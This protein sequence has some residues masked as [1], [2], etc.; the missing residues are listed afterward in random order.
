MRSAR[1]LASFFGMAAT[2][3]ASAQ[4]TPGDVYLL[5]LAIPSGSAPCGG[6]AIEHLV[7][8]ATWTASVIARPALMNGRGCY[9]PYRDRLVVC[10]NPNVPPVLCSSAGAI[11]TLPD[12][13]DNLYSL[14]ATGANG[15]I[16]VWG[17][18]QTSYYDSGNTW[19]SLPDVG[20]SAPFV[21]TTAGSVGALTYDAGTNCLFFASAVTG[22][23][24]EIAKV[25]LNASGTQVTGAPLRIT[26]DA[27]S[28]P[29]G[30]F[31]VGFSRGPN[32]TLFLKVDDN[33]NNTAGR[34]RLIDPVTLGVSVFAS[35]GYFGVG[36][37]IAGAYVPALGKALVLDTLNDSLRLF[38][39]GEA[40]AGASVTTGGDPLSGCGSGELAQV[41]VIEGPTAS[42]C[43]ANCDGNTTPPL[44]S[45]GDFVCFLSK[46]R[47]GAAY[48]NCD[49]STAQPLLSAGDFVCFLA[50]FRAGCS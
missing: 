22:D 36:G 29:N 5:S 49:G 44:L 14:A 40:G 16:Y 20:G 35:S 34:M 39:S 28:G 42:T 7:S 13:G 4:F 31:P 10:G 33:S 27:S 30:E 19:H 24:I 47:A 1:W 43:Y 21:F 17:A 12:A 15:F 38:A 11:A 25:P 23:L 9:D 26:F 37:E 8:G 50:R 3:A 6:P 18:A 48:A 41:I 32:G 45:A 2:S 46:F